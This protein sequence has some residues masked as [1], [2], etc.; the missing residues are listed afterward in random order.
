MTSNRDRSELRRATGRSRSVGF[1]GSVALLVLALWVT[2]AAGPSALEDALPEAPFRGWLLFEGKLCNR[3]HGIDSGGRGVGPDLAKGHFVGSFLDQGAAL[4]NHVPGM[5][6][7]FETAKLVWPELSS[8]E[9]LELAA[10]FYCVEYLGRPGNAETGQRLFASKGCSVCHAI[11]G[12]KK[13]IGPVL[14]D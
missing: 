4:W 9:V 7:Q 14:G 5:Q 1:A 12:R 13:R 6:V 8:A 2:T 3:C 11:D 10:F